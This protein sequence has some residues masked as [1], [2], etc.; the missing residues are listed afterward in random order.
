MG[1]DQGGGGGG[2]G[3]GE[4]SLRALLLQ[5]WHVVLRRRLLIAVILLACLAAGPRLHP[6]PAAAQPSTATSRIEISRAKKNITNVEG[7]NDTSAN[8][9]DY[10]FFETQYHLLKAHSLAE[11]VARNLNLAQ[12]RAFFAAHGVD[13]AAGQPGGGAL[14]HKERK[15]REDIA[16]GLLAGSVTAWSRIRRWSTSPTPAAIRRFRPGSPMPGPRNTS[17]R[18]W[19]ANMR[20]TPMRGGSSKGC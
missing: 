3:G 16:A 6:A 11:R 17:P 10:E 13:I 4:Q 1:F 12:N 19:T 7:V 8:A 15:R 18:P 2:G 9:Y 5:Y 14:D 20:R